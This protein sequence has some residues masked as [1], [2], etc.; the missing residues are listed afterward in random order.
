MAHSV[1]NGSSSPHTL[2]LHCILAKSLQW[3]RNSLYKRK[4]YYHPSPLLGHRIPMIDRLIFSNLL[5][6]P[7]GGINCAW[8][9]QGSVF[10]FSRRLNSIKSSRSD[11]IWLKLIDAE[12]TCSLRLS[13]LNKGWI[14]STFF[15]WNSAISIFSVSPFLR[16]HRRTDRGSSFNGAS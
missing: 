7:N 9:E 2:W 4:T 5:V 16:A 15:W 8:A 3:K 12:I 10:K 6:G 14:A 11:K 13:D 1:L